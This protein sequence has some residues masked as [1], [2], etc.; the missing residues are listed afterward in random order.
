MAWKRNPI[1]LVKELRVGVD[2]LRKKAAR[3]FLM[4]AYNLSPIKTGRYK[5]NHIVS[6]GSP[7]YTFD[8]R[9]RDFTRW[10]AEGVAIINNSPRGANIYIQQNLP[11]ARLIE[12]GSSRQ[13]PTGVY[14]IAYMRVKLG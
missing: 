14:K 3:Q 9:R 10:Y 11:Y 5:S 4:H 8:A 13:A 7:S 1:D 2:D 12:N 6:I